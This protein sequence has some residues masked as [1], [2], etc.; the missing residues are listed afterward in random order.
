M[1]LKRKIIFQQG[2]LGARIK[3]SCNTILSRA[4]LGKSSQCLFMMKTKE[5]NEMLYFSFIVWKLI[6]HRIK[7]PTQ[8]LSPFLTRA[9]VWTSWSHQ[10]WIPKSIR[11]M[12]I[13]SWVTE[14]Q[15][16]KSDWHK[17]GKLGCKQ[18]Y[19][20][21]DSLWTKTHGQLQLV[22]TSPESALV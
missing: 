14:H 22:S 15:V 19:M 17:M 11:K 13:L 9:S 1:H 8:G 7:A 4:G 5:K 3:N 18:R 6:I 21:I 12:L 2:H 10:D 20:I 16:E